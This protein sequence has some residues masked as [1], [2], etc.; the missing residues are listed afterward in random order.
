MFSLGGSVSSLFRRF[1]CTGANKAS[2]TALASVMLF[3]ISTGVVGAA[4]DKSFSPTTI[5]AG[6]VSVLTFTVANPTGA[7]ALSNVGFVD[8]LPAGLQV[9]NPA[10]VGGTCS[11]AAAAT[12]AV[13]GGTTITVTNL[14]VPA[15]AATCTVTVNITNAPSQF[16]QSCIGN[17]ASFTN[18]SGNVTVSNVANSVQPSCL[19]VPTISSAPAAIPTTS[20]S[21]VL[22]MIASI[23]M[24][25]VLTLRSRGKDVV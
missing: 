12:T 4:L 17:P 3:G 23:G 2:L 5:S 21:L 25:A 16:N 14:N 9:A 19:V 20:G 24:I 22:L 15:G 1:F 13:A 18:A 7:G 10:S 11:N 8:T 6:G